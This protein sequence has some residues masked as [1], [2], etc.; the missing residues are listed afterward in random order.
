MLKNRNWK[1]DI[2]LANALEKYV[3]Q[4]MKKSEILDIMIRDFPKYNCSL[5]SLYLRLK[6]F[7]I[8]N[9]G[10]SLD[11]DVLRQVI[12]SELDGSSRLPGVDEMELRLQV[13]YNLK[14]S[15]SLLDEVMRDLRT[16]REEKTRNKKKPSMKRIVSEEPIA[17]TLFLNDRHDN[18]DGRF[19]KSL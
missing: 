10:S 6:R 17:S 16:E 5:S 15:S 3:A 19:L 8:S 18:I 13:K 1:Y 11:I 12:S 9:I 7:Q 14:A 4:R 2:C